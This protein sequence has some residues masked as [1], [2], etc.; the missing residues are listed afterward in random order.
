MSFSLNYFTWAQQL[1][2]PTD[3]CNDTIKKKLSKGLLDLLWE[4]MS[5]AI[6]PQQEIS[7]VRKNILLHKLK[8]NCNEPLIVC[9]RSI[10]DLN[11]EKDRLDSQIDISEREL[12]DLNILLQ[13]KEYKLKKAKTDYKD[14]QA[15]LNLLTLKY[16]EY[17]MQVQ[18]CS[19]M[20]QACKHLMPNNDD[21]YNEEK[22]KQSLEAV[23]TLFS[24]ANK[25]DVCKNISTMLGSVNIPSLWTSLY[26]I[27]AQNMEIINP[28][29]QEIGNK[30]NMNNE[31]GENIEIGIARAHN[32]HIN[33]FTKTIAYDAKVKQ[34]EEII[35]DFIEQ[36]EG[37]CVNLEEISEWLALKL[38]VHKLKVKQETLQNEIEK[39]TEIPFDSNSNFAQIISEI[40]SIDSIME[41]CI[42]D[43][44]KSFSLLKS[45]PS[46]ILAIRDKVDIPMQKIIGLQ[47]TINQDVLWLNN[48][49]INELNL[50]FNDLNINALKKL[51]MKKKS[52]S[53][54][55][56]K[57]TLTETQLDIQ[58][59]P[60]VI[61]HCEKTS[62]PIYFLIQCYKTIMLNRSL[63]KIDTSE[64]ESVELKD[65]E[66]LYNNEQDAILEILNSTRAVC[67]NARG[68]IEQ[69][70]K[71]ENEWSK[72]TV[73]AAMEVVDHTVDGATFKEWQERYNKLIFM[74]QNARK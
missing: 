62:L 7:T 34:Y 15:R 59:Y 66:S 29:K 38:E 69:F 67:T 49:L 70:G 47:A 43:I 51:P 25:K 27:H 14:L 19:I 42:Q 20:L 11:K 30:S 52:G 16:H 64:H 71:V 56:T 23:L 39:V 40:R 1:K 68:Q 41:T 48:D 8:N 50:F 53:G 2:C 26:Q 6:F 33:L 37:N 24:G 35:M 60:K 45:A 44:Q 36:I 46:L 73:Q 12:E 5:C 3:I 57:F 72:Q 22:V 18:D 17:N 55:L 63:K 4:E 54:R 28:A 9:T 74:L 31:V 13:Q 61:A 10:S 32:L 21:K 58:E 65:I